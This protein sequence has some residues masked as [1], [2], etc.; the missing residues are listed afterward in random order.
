[1]VCTGSTHH[2][3][4]TWIS[5]KRKLGLKIRPAVYPPSALVCL[6][7]GRRPAVE[8]AFLLTLLLYLELQL[9]G[10]STWLAATR[11][12]NRCTH[13]GAITHNGNAEAYTHGS[14][15]QAGRLEGGSS[16]RGVR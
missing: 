3:D 16:A 9:T 10:C 15:G 6:E 14:G 4:S 7:F 13:S 1:M 12:Q 5:V 11:L 8:R 2:L